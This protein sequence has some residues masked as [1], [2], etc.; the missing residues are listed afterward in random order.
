MYG[1]PSQASHIFGVNKMYDFD[2]AKTKLRDVNSVLQK[3]PEAAESI[4]K[5]KIQNPNG[6]H[7][8][9]VGLNSSIHV[10]IEGSVGYYCAGMNEEAE[11][12]IKGSAGP[13]VAE[14]MMS[15]TVSISGNV[16]QSAGA[17]AHGGLLYVNGDA[18]SRCGISLKGADIV[19]G[20]SV[21][22]MSAFMAQSGSLLVC[23]DAGDALGDSLYEADIYVRG[24]V[25]SLGVDCIEKEIRKKDTDKIMDLLS[26]CKIEDINPDEFKRFGSER[27]LYNF[28]IDNISN[29]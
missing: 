12:I 16:S 24:K 1:S 29:Y 23:G 14:N 7:A 17:S 20:G 13:G 8:V 9:A 2:L 11:V 22:H 19:V 10:E 21:G 27:K 18:S 28:D 15:G 3:Q 26:K 4:K 6:A 25:K 5:W